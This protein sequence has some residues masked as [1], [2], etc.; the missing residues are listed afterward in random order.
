M[1]L[2]GLTGGAVFSIGEE[3]V[4]AEE[5]MLM[6]KNAELRKQ[7]DVEELAKS[8]SMSDFREQFSFNT[9][10][11]VKFKVTNILLYEKAKSEA[12]DKIDEQLSF[13]NIS[14]IRFRS[15]SS[16]LYNCSRDLL[17]RWGKLLL[18]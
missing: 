12:G 14:A 17:I 1:S 8:V 9:S 2:P 10:E 11:I 13:I 3:T 16:S 15:S 5:V 6:L 4:T 7:R 18:L